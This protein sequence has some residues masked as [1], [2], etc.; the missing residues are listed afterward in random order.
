LAEPIGIAKGEHAYRDA[1]GEQ[2]DDARDQ[3][4]HVAE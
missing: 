3:Y 2:N 4:R 1:P